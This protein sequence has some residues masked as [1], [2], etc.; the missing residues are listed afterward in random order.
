MRIGVFGGSFNPVHYG[1]LL[2]AETC[3]VQAR[4]DE[5]WFVP[6]ATPPH[7]Q[8][9]ALAPDQDRVAM[10]QLAMGGHTPFRVSEI[11]LQRGGL[12][13]TVDTLGEIAKGRPDADLF[14]LMGA[15]SLADWHSWRAPDEICRLATP[16]VV[17]RAGSPRPSL[18]AFEPF[19]DKE[20]LAAIAAHQ[21]EMPIIEL[22]SSAIRDA[23]QR[24]ES[25]RFQTPRAVEKYIETNRLYQLP[26]P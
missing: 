9:L 13:Y 22:S 26:E 12:S 5:I 16:L 15:D 2:L 18:D 10:L 14:F 4:L 8:D 6:A 11:E 17:H 1:H 25:I 21:V 3:R 7:K 20:R 24:G 23:V 19:A